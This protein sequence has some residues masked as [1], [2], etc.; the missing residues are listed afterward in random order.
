VDRF[1]EAAA[2]LGSGD[3]DENAGSLANLAEVFLPC[4]DAIGARS[5]VE[6][7]AYRGKLTREL[8]RW[9]AGV[10]GHVT[11][12]DPAPQA[13]LL[14]LAARDSRLELIPKTSQEALPSLPRPD[15]LLIDGDHNYYTLSEE[16]RLIDEKATG[17]ELPLLILHDVGWPL[18]RRDSYSDPDRIPAGHRQ[19]FVRDVA[20]V[21]SDPGVSDH[22]MPFA[23]VAAR[24]G[25]PGNGVLTAIED[26]VS[27]HKGLRLATVPAFFGLGVV[28][29]ESAPWADV[30]AEI[31][32]RWNRD[33]LIERLEANRVVQVAERWANARRLEVER[34]HRREQEALLRA[35]LG[36]SAFALAERLSRLRQRGDPVFSR[37]Q[38]RRILGET[39]A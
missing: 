18:G 2:G 33:P 37:E 15:A 23:C 38:V 32:G 17:P 4:L 3:P 27:G 21:P 8:V 39:E 26:F 24:E 31:V 34:R 10:E 16:L 7:G 19:P 11:A 14:E 5:V 28:W 1:A 6:I 25:G 13:E 9:A 12:I 35:M 36:S 29:H 20:L 30:V 22:G